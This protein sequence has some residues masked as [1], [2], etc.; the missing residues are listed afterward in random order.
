MST[1]Q[2]TI[3]ELLEWINQLRERLSESNHFL[4]DHYGRIKLLNDETLRL[5]Q[6]LDNE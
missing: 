6:H 5:T 3:A 2:P 4:P 1:E